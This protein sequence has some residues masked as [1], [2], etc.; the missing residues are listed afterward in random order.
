MSVAAKISVGYFV[1]GVIYIGLS[2]LLMGLYHGHDFFDNIPVLSA[3]ILKGWAFF[4]VT[5]VLLYII[6]RRFL[7]RLQEQ[8]H[9]LTAIVNNTNDWLWLIDRNAR[10]LK[11]NKTFI[12]ISRR[13]EVELIG[14][15][16]ADMAIT[17]ED[18]DKW[19]AYYN[20]SLKGEEVHFTEEVVDRTGKSMHMEFHLFPIANSAGNVEMVACFGHDVTNMKNV[21][22]EIED[23]NNTLKEITWMQAHVIRKPVANI[24]GLIDALD[25]VQLDSKENRQLLQLIRGQSDEL[26]LA[27]RQIVERASAVGDKSS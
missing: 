15:Q 9:L 25:I 4:L 5:S 8:R 10:L 23:Q 14:I 24:Q 20:S 3:S 1:S 21:Q 12:R 11:A 22:K 27:I 18:R 26:D 7:K 19:R 2:D 6:L 13:T 16:P 17:P